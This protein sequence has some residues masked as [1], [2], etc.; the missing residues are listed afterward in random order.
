MSTGRSGGWIDTDQGTVTQRWQWLPRPVLAAWRS[1]PLGFVR[2]VLLRIAAEALSRIYELYKLHPAVWRWTARHYHPAMGRFA[3]LHAWMTCQYAALEVPA[4]AEHLRRN[5][6]QFRWWDIGS[7]PV[8]DKQNYV[9]TYSEESR[10]WGGHLDRVGTVVDESSGSSGT[11]FNWVRGKRELD[12]IHRNV[13]GFTSQIYPRRRLFVINAYSMGAWATGT[14]T[15]IAMAKVAMVK[16]TGP[17]L[18]KI[19]DTVTHFGPKY[20]YLVTAYPPFLK[21]LRD[22][23]DAESE[24]GKFDWPAFRMYGMVG[25]EGMTEALRSYCEER[26]ISVLSGYGASDLTIGI[27]GESALTVWLRRQLVRDSELRA[28]LLG[29]GESR[30]PMIFQYNPLETFLETNADG[31]LVCTLNN[32]SV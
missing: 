27:G 30:I 4:Y 18:D 11:P 9:T 3:R 22:R 31:E 26:F 21:D 23:L 10:C 25:G 12:T 32:T 20:T 29:A 14:N 19:V 6:F 13:A 8:T 15:G 1:R 7:Y 17:D 24:A 5:G 28:A 2:R 16:N